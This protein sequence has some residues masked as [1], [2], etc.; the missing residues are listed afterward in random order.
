MKL[1]LP[2]NVAT[3][4]DVQALVLEVRTYAKWY[5]QY[6][7]KKRLRLKSARQEPDVSAAAKELIRDWA[8]QKPLSTASLDELVTALNSFESTAP[9]ITIT[10][11]APPTAGVKKTLVG[12]CR[13]KIAPNI[14]VNFQFNAE[15]LGGLVVRSGSHIFD[16]SFRRQILS[17]QDKFP[18]YLRRV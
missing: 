17:A 4:Q 10:L 18:E 5:S 7:I 9:Q 8:M 6:A 12:W 15:L 1:Q 2:D 16:W 3:G 11:A 14:L 13:N